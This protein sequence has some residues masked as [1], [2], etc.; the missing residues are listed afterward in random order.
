M[1]DTTEEK[2]KKDENLHRA[3]NLGHTKGVITIG[4][5]PRFVFCPSCSSDSAKNAEKFYKELE[6]K[7][8]IK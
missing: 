7:Q 4:S 5:S 8:K 6:K 2:H 1:K 3:C